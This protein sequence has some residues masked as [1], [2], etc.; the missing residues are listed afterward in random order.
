MEHCNHAQPDSQQTT[1]LE[2]VECEETANEEDDTLLIDD[3]IEEIDPPK[4]LGDILESIIGA[5]F[6][7]C[8]MDLELVWSKICRFFQP[9]IGL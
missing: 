2:D 4:A 8:G 1:S 6:L 5:L 3:E 9:L 7:D